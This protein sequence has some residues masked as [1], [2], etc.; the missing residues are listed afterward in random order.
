M[1]G[2]ENANFNAEFGQ[3]EGKMASTMGEPVNGGSPPTILVKLMSSI[4]RELCVPLCYL[5]P[6]HPAGVKDQVIVIAG[7]SDN[8]GLEGVV[9]EACRED[10]TRSWCVQLS[11]DLRTAPVRSDAMWSMR[12]HLAVRGK[13]AVRIVIPLCI[14]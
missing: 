7:N 11:K 2:V 8:V 12:R 3:Y 10:Q 4:A 6:V 14:Q 9:T 5:R 1:A 13:V